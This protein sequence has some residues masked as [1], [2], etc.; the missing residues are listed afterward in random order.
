MKKKFIPDAK[1]FSASL[2]VFIV[3]IPLSLGISLASGVP[4]EAGLISAIIGGIIVG[5]LAGAP[6]M[7]SGPA[8]GLSALVFQMVTDYGFQGLLF[9]TIFCGLFQM[10]FSLFKAG[11]LFKL[12]PDSILQ[13]M[14][15][16]IGLLIMA[17]QMHVM[18]GHGVPS[19]F[20]QGL[21]QLPEKFISSLSSKMNF[22]ILCLGLLGII[23]QAYWNKIA[24][25]KILKMIPA[26]LVSVIAITCFALA[27][28]LPRVELAAGNLLASN[29][30]GQSFDIS[31]NQIL[32]YL[33][34][35]FIFCAIASAE[36]LLTA[37]A[38][39][40][41]QPGDKELSDKK[42]NK[43]LMAQGIGNTLCGL[44]GGIPITG[45]IVRSA[46][47]INAGAKSRWSTILHG[48][49]I[50]VFVVFFAKI[51]NLVPLTALASVLI[52][53]GWKLL[54]VDK[55]IKLFKTQRIDF[56]FVTLTIVSIL[57]SNLMVGL[58]SSL[59]IFWVYHQWFRKN[60]INTPV[61]PN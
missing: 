60:V 4:I 30:L 26:A 54:G 53:T 28:E 43:E 16:A 40:D 22:S 25:T 45:V 32:L 2:V 9:I 10:L 7:V 1:D 58:I 11:P 37:R 42:L 56:Y 38:L 61:T 31:L 51:I 24:K 34:F 29:F 19:Q 6:L 49:W 8:A 35:G 59:F 41:L 33:G 47:N 50:L 14:L 27:I 48:F 13:G 17:G 20:F 52:F 21:G 18:L 36:S 39:E 23:I 57:L 5:T 44:F 3:A 55:L 12:I 46:A 15:A